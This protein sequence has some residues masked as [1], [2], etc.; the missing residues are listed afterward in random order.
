LLASVSIPLELQHKQTLERRMA[1]KIV[2]VAVIIPDASPL[3]TLDRVGR[4]DLL[5]LFGAPIK[6]VDQVHFEV[7]KP[8]NDPEGRLSAWFKKKG[9]EVEIIETMTGLGFQQM[10][11]QGKKPPAGAGERAV[12]EYAIGLART[13]GPAFVPLV[14]FEDP[15]V[16]EL[17]IAK[18]KDIH[19]LNTTA[20][21]QTMGAEG[22]IN[23]A[24]SIIDAI[25]AL[26]K[27][28]M[29]PFDKP[30]RTQKVRSQYTRKSRDA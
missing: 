1:K 3:L 18:M 16:L 19:L 30:A 14:L 29:E 7:T 22:L 9:N 20:F 23:D 5:D 2:P 10:L 12:E 25:N 15:D 17:R 13:T 4:L 26:R 21:I 6:I 8:P 24:S 28:P 11:R 27:T